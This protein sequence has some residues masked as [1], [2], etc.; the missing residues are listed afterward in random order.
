MSDRI[1]NSPSSPL[2][3][4]HS[5]LPPP[6]KAGPTS[7]VERNTIEQ[8]ERRAIHGDGVKTLGRDALT[9]LTRK[10]DFDQ[11]VEFGCKVAVSDGVAA[12]VEGK[13]SI[14]RRHDGRYEVR[15]DAA[16]QVG[17]GEQHGRA[18]AGV[19]GGT[20]FVVESPEAAADIAHAIA[21][22]GVSATVNSNIGVNFLSVP[23]DTV[24]GTTK[25][26]VERLQHYRENLVDARVDARGT[27]VLSEG[28]HGKGLN[29]H[30]S[31]GGG[32][33]G[34]L[35]V[36]FEKGELVESLKLGLE[37]EGRATLNLG[38]GIVANTLSRTAG[39]VE[40]ESK[41]DV[42]IEK[43]T[44]LDPALLERAKHG[45]VS[46]RELVA[47][48]E[49]SHS[50]WVLTAEHETE[51]TF[52]GG[53]QGT[54]KVKVSGELPVSAEIAKKALEGGGVAELLGG[55]TWKGGAEI[56]LGAEVAGDGD[57]GLFRGGVTTFKKLGETEGSLD[58]VFA[59]ARAQLS[60]E[61]QLRTQLEAERAV[62]NLR[63]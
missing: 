32:T 9:G 14:E 23:L 44:H 5:E 63:R 4:H 34:E 38:H 53:V 21:T 55:L 33:A 41:T 28:T 10:L 51:L 43:R 56:G 54:G 15:A 35:H 12:Q 48:M 30:L 27:G 31:A 40:G 3:S 45:D 57:I 52:T 22:L 49:H 8:L 46:P 42:R 47:A 50:E 29:Q 18:V 36:D 37:G 26:A 60:N 61:Q 62:L 7:S 39:S 20:T 13:V 11:S 24:T 1:S 58:E 25:F 59:H 17:V 2:A 19:G 6:P 16:A